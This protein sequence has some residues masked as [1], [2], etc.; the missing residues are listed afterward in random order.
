[1]KPNFEPTDPNQYN[2]G[3]TRGGHHP[4]EPSTESVTEELPLP[5]P[6]ATQIPAQTHQ[7]LLNQLQRMNIPNPATFTW[8]FTLNGNQITVIISNHGL[9]KYKF[10]I[11]NTN[12]DNFVIN[13]FKGWAMEGQGP[14]IAGKDIK[15]LYLYTCKDC[16]KANTSVLPHVYICPFKSCGLG[17]NCHNPTKGHRG[18][19]TYYGHFHY[20]QQGQLIYRF[21]CNLAQEI[22]EAYKN[23]ALRLGNPTCPLTLFQHQ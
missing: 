13:N 23:G 2:I 7:Q 8:N 4:F 19:C 5:A 3:F 12:G 11:N 22:C 15:T 16:A 20:P 18:Y 9:N 21:D 1:M 17:V 14:Y 10:S 6:Q